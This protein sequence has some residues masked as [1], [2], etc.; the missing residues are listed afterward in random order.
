M[1]ECNY[2][3]KA[4]FRDADAATEARPRLA[5]L[6]AEGERAYDYWQEAR[7]SE[8]PEVTA[9]EFWAGFRER[10]PLTTNY[11]GELAGVEDWDDELVGHLGSL[12][13]PERTGPRACAT[14]T[15]D[16]DLLLLQLNMIWHFSDIGLLERH[17]FLELDA[18][19]VGSISDETAEKLFAEQTGRDPEPG[20][21][22]FDTIWV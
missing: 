1:G 22:P 16:D 18:L 12:I 15:Q 21:D 13:D 20:F 9:D 19:A 4:R 3:L 5:A 2:Y 14:L 11:L 8:N 7:R 10:F 6:L 17:C